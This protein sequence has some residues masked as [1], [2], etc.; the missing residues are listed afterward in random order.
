VVDEQEE[1]A[2]PKV[3]EVLLNSLWYADLIFVLHNL[4]AP[5]GLTNTKAIF[6]K[7]KALKLCIL[8]ANLYWKDPGGIFLNFLLKDKDDKVLQEFH[9]GDCG[10][11]LSWKTTTNKRLRASFYWP[12]LFI[13]VHNKVTY[14][15]K[16]QV[17][18]G[19][20][21]LPLPMK[22][23]LVEAPFQQWGLEFIGEIHPSSLDQH[24]WILTATDY[25]TK[26]IDIMPCRQA[27]D[28]VIIKFLET[29]ILSCF[30]CP[31]KIIADNV[32]TFRSKKLKYFCSQ[33]QITLGNSTVYYP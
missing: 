5:S 32:A 18:K 4:Q 3:K 2:T 22:P 21:L 7:L 9:V 13:D 15:H 29:N 8:E 16:F 33:Y 12:T 10:G 31:R 24:K 17:F 11:H 26:W 19:K 20:K 28:F 14:C 6:I 23:I 25:F 30:G 1:K 27:T